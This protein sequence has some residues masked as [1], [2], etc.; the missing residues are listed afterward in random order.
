ML[1]TVGLERVGLPLLLGRTMSDIVPESQG[2]GKNM[3]P[4][5]AVVTG[6]EDQPCLIIRAS[7]IFI[8]W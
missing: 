5:Q 2:R 6:R 1:T 7:C 3:G 8:R 4:K